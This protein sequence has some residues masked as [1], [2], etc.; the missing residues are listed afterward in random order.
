M[1]FTQD[2]QVEDPFCDASYQ[3]AVNPTSVITSSVCGLSQFK[4]TF[5]MHRSMDLLS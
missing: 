5:S 4:L 1:I 3:S 2:S